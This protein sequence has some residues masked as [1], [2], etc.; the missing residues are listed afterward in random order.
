M[1]ERKR[2]F[3]EVEGVWECMLHEREDETCRKNLSERREVGR[4]RSTEAKYG[5]KRLDEFYYF[6]AETQT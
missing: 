5:W 2:G 4:G 6:Y 3:K 1:K